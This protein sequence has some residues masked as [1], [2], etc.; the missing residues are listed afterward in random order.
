[1]HVLFFH[2]LASKELWLS[3]TIPVNIVQSILSKPWCL[4]LLSSFRDYLFTMARSTSKNS[5]CSFL[6][7][8][9]LGSQPTPHFLYLDR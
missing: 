8:A 5:L 7:E 9:V 6:C 4:L 2:V 3:Y 1:M